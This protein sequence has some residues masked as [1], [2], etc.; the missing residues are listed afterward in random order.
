MLQ[1][2]GK[3]EKIINFNSDQK[4]II[5]RKKRNQALIFELESLN[6]REINV[7]I[8]F[9]HQK[10]LA[11]Q[12]ENNQLYILTNKDFR[13][14]D[15][16][17]VYMTE[18]SKSIITSCKQKQWFFN[19]F[20]DHRKTTIVMTEEARVCLRIL[21]PEYHLLSNQSSLKK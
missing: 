1:K 21:I 13:V 10:I 8:P 9:T 18:T 3:G 4:S 16:E 7:Q 12:E 20:R 14:Y 15:S 17:E 2:M 19:F 5:I 11:L 6:I